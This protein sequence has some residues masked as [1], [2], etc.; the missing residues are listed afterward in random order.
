MASEI[1]NFGVT[2]NGLDRAQIDVAPPVD[3]PTDPRPPTEALNYQKPSIR[4]TVKDNLLSVVVHP[5]YG[6]NKIKAAISEKHEATANEHHEHEHDPDHAP[7]LAPAPPISSLENERLEHSLDEKPKFPPAKEFIKHPMSSV[8]S[9]VQDQ[10]GSDWA[11]NM[12]KSEIAHGAEVQIVRQAD[13]VTNASTEPEKAAELQTLVQLKQ[14]R[15]DEMVRWSIDRHVRRVGRTHVPEKPPERPPLY[16]K[17]D[18]S[19]SWSKYFGKVSRGRQILLYG[20]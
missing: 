19:Q 12:A 7:T 1:N 2:S 16:S 17:Q 4:R 14:T 6:I 10:R 20:D 13:K 11:E 15:Q 5:R 18:P 9:T 3:A 8:Q